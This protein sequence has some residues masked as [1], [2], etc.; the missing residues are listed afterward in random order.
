MFV[1]FF[2]VWES[3]NIILSI[4]LSLS[5]SLSIHVRWEGVGMS[6]LLFYGVAFV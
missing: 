2:C 4:S 6:V 3:L 5:L 1:L